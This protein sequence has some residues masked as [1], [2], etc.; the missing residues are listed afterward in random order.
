MLR[1]RDLSR[2]MDF[3]ESV[4]LH[5]ADE[6]QQDEGAIIRRVST[7]LLLPLKWYPKG[8]VLPSR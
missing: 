3:F 8:V 2:R 7:I 5:P 6:V 4:E 1:V